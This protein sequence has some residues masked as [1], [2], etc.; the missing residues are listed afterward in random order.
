MDLLGWFLNFKNMKKITAL[1][2]LGLISWSALAQTYGNHGTGR[3]KD[4]T[5]YIYANGSNNITSS[6]DSIAVDTLKA[7]DELYVRDTALIDLI[8]AYSSTP[9]GSSG[10]L[11][12]N[13]AGSFDGASILQ[14]S[15][16][17]GG[18]GPGLGIGQSADPLSL[19]S[20]T[21][22][23]AI[24]PYTMKLNSSAGDAIITFNGTQSQIR[25]NGVNIEL[26]AQV[27]L[28]LVADSIFASGDLYLQNKLV[29]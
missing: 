16:N 17:S 1:L 28:D 26:E 8:N 25:S 20:V 12:W 18:G 27:N 10:E 15:S 19:I 13:N 3:F 23:A 2:I 14:Y 29:C 5:G 6:T 11:Q 24:Y 21:H 9:G 22:N 4:H 7:Y